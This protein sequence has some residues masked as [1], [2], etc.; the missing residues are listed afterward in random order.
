MPARKE[1]RRGPA[2]LG[3]ILVL[4]GAVFLATNV[5]GFQLAAAWPLFIIV[6]GLILLAASFAAGGE[7]GGGLAITGSIVTTVGLILAVQEATGLYA[8]WAYAWALVA[9][10]SVGVGML[11]FGS[12]TGRP[13]PVDGRDPVGRHRPRAVRRVR[14]L[15]RGR[16][17]AVRGRHAAARRA[18]PDRADRARRDPRRRQRGEPRQVG[19]PAVPAV[20]GAFPWATTTKSVTNAVTTQSAPLPILPWHGRNHEGR[21]AVRHAPVGGHDPPTAVPWGGSSDERTPMRRSLRARQDQPGHVDLAWHGRMTDTGPPCVLLPW[22]GKPAP[23]RRRRAGA[24]PT[25]TTR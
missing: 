10:G 24:Q 9:P 19:H 5:T 3:V 18:P 23:R 2:V 20:P 25:D 22:G 1:D 13:G 21:L 11:L 15:L 16:D 8:T 14:A 7:A 17:R 12:F 4:V 6:P